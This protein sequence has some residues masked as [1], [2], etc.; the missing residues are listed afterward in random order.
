MV[1]VYLRTYWKRSLGILAHP[2]VGR[3]MYL[4]RQRLNEGQFQGLGPRTRSGS[5]RQFFS[6]G[7]EAG[8]PRLLDIELGIAAPNWYGVASCCSPRAMSR[9]RSALRAAR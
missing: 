4:I 9:A 7:T 3:G 1:T 6:V 5:Q 2:G 8:S